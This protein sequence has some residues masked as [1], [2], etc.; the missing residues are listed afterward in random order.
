MYVVEVTKIMGK[1]TGLAFLLMT[2]WLLLASLLL[3]QLHSHPFDVILAVASIV[4]PHEAVHALVAKIVGGKKLS[5][6]VWKAGK[7]IVLGFYVCLEETLPRNRWVLVAAAPLLL[8]LLAIV[9]AATFNTPL[10]GYFT[11]FA[12]LNAVGCSGDLALILYAVSAGK[13]VSIKDGGYYIGIEG[14]SPSP[15][16][17][18]VLDSLAAAGYA[19]LALHILMMLLTP[20]ATMK[21]SIDVLGVEIAKMRVVDSV[22]VVSFSQW[23]YALA[24]LMTIVSSISV[25]VYSLKRIPF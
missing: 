4:V 1:V 20:L 15:K 5:M 23:F 18:I 19:L 21:G 11:W 3:G 16:T 14:G 17:L 9:L 22:V 24:C 12:V 25:L 7:R 6:G 13:H 10:R 2:A 8:S